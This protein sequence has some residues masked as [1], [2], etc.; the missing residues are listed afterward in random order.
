MG[1]AY[2]CTETSPLRVHQLLKL[3]FFPVITS[4]DR[5]MHVGK[6]YGEA[7]FG[8]EYKY[9]RVVKHCS[10]Q[11]KLLLDDFDHTSANSVD[12]P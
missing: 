1:G 7:T 9:Y 3:G 5:F 2:Q 8:L 10:F 11:A 12:R 4:R 6:S